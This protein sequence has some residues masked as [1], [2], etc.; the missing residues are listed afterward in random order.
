MAIYK[1]SAKDINS[2]KVYGKVEA[3]SREE[4]VSLLRSQNLYL[5]QCKEKEESMSQYKIPL[6]DLSEFCRQLGTMISSGMS[7]IVAMGIVTKR[8]SNVKLEKVYKAVYIKLQQGFTL[9][10]AL[11]SQGKAFPNL[12]INMMRASE[13][14]GLMDKTLIKLANQFDKENKINSKVKT[15]MYYPIGLVIVTLIVVLLVFTIILPNF[16]I[17][18]EGM[19]MPLIT[20]VMFGISDVIIHYWYWI[21]IVVLVLIAIFTYALRIDKVRLRFDE[22]KLSVPIAGKLLVIIYTGRYARSMS[23]LYSSGVSMIN[24]LNLA[25]TTINNKYIEQQFDQVM[26]SVRDGTNLSTAINEVDGF[27]AKLPSSIYVGE[28]S[29]RLDEML[30]RIADDFDFESEIA[31]EKLVILLQPLMIIILGVLICLVVISVLLPIYGLY[32]SVS[33]K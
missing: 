4:V 32:S 25:R 28:E 8:E 15:A 7:L 31:I 3:N 14:S 18:F 2:K 23:S 11:A 33:G 26:K 13:S 20:K 16:L 30:D 29:G 24:S 12:M 21:L 6:K 10:N 9:S 22:M 27:D 5:L 1:Y 17:V 19:E